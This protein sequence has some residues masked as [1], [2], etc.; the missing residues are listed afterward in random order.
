MWAMLTEISRTVMWGTDDKTTKLTAGD[1][2]TLFMDGLKRERRCVPSLDGKGL[3]NLSYKTS[4]LS[5][6]EMG[7]LIELMYEF[8]ARYFVDFKT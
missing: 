4:E 8:G 1:W 2:K 3:V 7:E 5:K 6:E